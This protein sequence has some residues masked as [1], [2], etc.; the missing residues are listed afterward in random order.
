MLSY[1]P[2]G[3]VCRAAG[4]KTNCGGQWHLVERRI[5]NLSFLRCIQTSKLYHLHVLG[6]QCLFKWVIWDLEYCVCTEIILYREVKFQG[7]LTKSCLTCSEI[8]K[9]G[10]LSKTLLAESSS[11][12]HFTEPLQLTLFGSRPPACWIVH[13]V[14]FC[15]YTE[16][17]PHGEQCFSAGMKSN[18]QSIMPRICACSLQ[19]DQSS[20]TTLLKLIQTSIAH[21]P[22]VTPLE[23]CSSCVETGESLKGWL[24]SWTGA[25]L[26][27][28]TCSY[29][30]NFYLET[31]WYPSSSGIVA[32][33]FHAVIPWDRIT[34]AELQHG[35][36]RSTNLA[37][38]IPLADS[39]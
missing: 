12:M 14:V 23:S 2:G 26:K 10:R 27:P 32:C 3:K 39:G 33:M 36:W 7:K 22:V 20:L 6:E 30:T 5:R 4:C 18:F 29:V 34:A 37:P 35:S 28:L 13:P 11:S 8:I 24:K 17:K 9:C 15:Y 16:S 38:G 19:R 1:S 25:V 21:S 31:S